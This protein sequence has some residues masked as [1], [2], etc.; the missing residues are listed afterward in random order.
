MSDK[1]NEQALFSFLDSE[2]STVISP[3]TLHEELNSWTGVDFLT[4]L[5]KTTLPDD[6]VKISNPLAFDTGLKKVVKKQRKA[7]GGAINK[8]VESS[9]RIEM[10]LP[11]TQATENTIFQTQSNV[12]SPSVTNFLGFSQGNLQGLANNIQQELNK[13][14]SPGNSGSENTHINTINSLLGSESGD[15]NKQIMQL[16]NSVNPTEVAAMIKGLSYLNQLK[17]LT[18]H[19]EVPKNRALAPKATSVQTQKNKPVINNLAEID[20][21]LNSSSNTAVSLSLSSNL[22]SPDLAHPVETSVST[23]G[24]TKELASDYTQRFGSLN[25]GL[26]HINSFE[27]LISQTK[28]YSSSVSDISERAPDSMANAAE[29]KRQRNTAASARFR[30]KKKMKEQML[31]KKTF[32]LSQKLSEMETK[33][34]EME[35]E[36]GWLRRLVVEKDPKILDAS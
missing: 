34:K 12:K 24:Y 28:T 30:I 21:I 17:T 31:E 32:E 29:D 5:S 16:F 8:Q 20:A 11:S 36:N 2:K 9:E 14:L 10:V 1:T 6:N 3:R 18:S 15:S 13:D 4:K 23:S 19:P 25:Q 7:D 26:S 27:H 33:L 22:N 35:M